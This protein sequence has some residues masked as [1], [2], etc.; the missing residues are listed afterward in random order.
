MAGHCQCV[1]TA[2]PGIGF[3]WQLLIRGSP[4]NPTL[5][6][7]VFSGFLPYAA[8]HAE[9]PQ[10]S[11]AACSPQ[12]QATVGSMSI[13]RSTPICTPGKARHIHTAST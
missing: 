7:A 8:G 4:P 3:C 13:G 6:E 5:F 9:Q 11:L 2:M 12:Q 10:S 1:A